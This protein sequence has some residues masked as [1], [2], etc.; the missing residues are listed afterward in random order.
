METCVHSKER[1]QETTFGNEYIDSTA[2]EMPAVAIITFIL[3]F[4]T[5]TCGYRWNQIRIAIRKD[6]SLK[7]THNDQR[8]AR[9]EISLSP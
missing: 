5:D 3:K 2:A 1:G 7:F 6:F 4:L 9:S 8:V